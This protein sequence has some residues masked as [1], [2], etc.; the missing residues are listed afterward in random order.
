MYHDVPRGIVVAFNIDN[1]STAIEEEQ[2]DFALL[3]T[4]KQTAIVGLCLAGAHCR[5]HSALFGE[6]RALAASSKITHI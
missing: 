6:V 5:S 1:W 4:W 2:P 3:S